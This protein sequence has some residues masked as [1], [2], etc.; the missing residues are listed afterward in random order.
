[1]NKKCTFTFDNEIYKKAH[2]VAI[3]SPLNIVLPTKM[4]GTKTE[5]SLSHLSRENL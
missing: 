2:G 4:C 1:M 3:E 5:K